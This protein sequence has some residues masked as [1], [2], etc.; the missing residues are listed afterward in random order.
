[1]RFTSALAASVIALGAVLSGFTAAAGT[2][3]PQSVQHRAVASGLPADTV[4]AQRETD[5]GNG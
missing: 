2:D 5:H 4:P 3:A 1:M